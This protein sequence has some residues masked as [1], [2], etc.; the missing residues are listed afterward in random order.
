MIFSFMAQNYDKLTILTEKP[1]HNTPIPNFIYSYSMI[2]CKI[3]YYYANYTKTQPR[4]HAF[5]CI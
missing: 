3:T 5:L 1:L 4:L 2:I